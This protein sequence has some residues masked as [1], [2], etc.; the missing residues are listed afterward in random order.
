MTLEGHKRE[1]VVSRILGRNRRP[2]VPGVLDLDTTLF[3]GKVDKD[4]FICQFYADDI[5]FGSTNKSFCDKFS[6]IMTGSFKMSMMGE[7]MFF[8]VFKS[9]NWKIV[10]TFH[11][12]ETLIKFISN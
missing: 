1:P 11:V 5:I 2:T 4:L 12:L 3:T 8:L 7:L 9:S 10:V 6:K